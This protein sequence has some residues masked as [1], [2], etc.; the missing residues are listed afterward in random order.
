M[1][2]TNCKTTFEIRVQIKSGNDMFNDQFITFVFDNMDELKEYYRS[3][4]PNEIC[5]YM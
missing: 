4:K 5:L 1:V 3:L 2:L